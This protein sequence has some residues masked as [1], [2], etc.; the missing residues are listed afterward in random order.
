MDHFE[1]RD[2]S[3]AI[4]IWAYSEHWE[5]YELV[6]GLSAYP[7][8]V[9]E[10]YVKANEN[11]IMVDIPDVTQITGDFNCNGVYGDPS[12]CPQPMPIKA[13]FEKNPA[14]STS[15]SGCHRHEFGENLKYFSGGGSGYNVATLEGNVLEGEI[16]PSLQIGGWSYIY[17]WN[18]KVKAIQYN[19]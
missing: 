16:D 19:K 2:G 15:K 11:H 9:P 6:S 17:F 13:I 1:Q 3:F 4:N 14:G 12:A 18:Q 8:N 10:Q 5:N 7:Q